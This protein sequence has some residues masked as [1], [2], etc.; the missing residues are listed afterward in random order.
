MPKAKRSLNSI[1]FFIGADSFVLKQDVTAM[2][3]QL[4]ADDPSASL[5]TLDGA[6]A[7]MEEILMMA[8]TPALFAQK[9]ILWIKNYK[10]LEKAAGKDDVKL[11]KDLAEGIPEDTQIVFTGVKADNRLKFVSE[12]KKMAEFIEHETTE[13]WFRNQKDAI[14]GRFQQRMEEDAFDLLYEFWKDN[15]AGFASELEKIS[16]YH[17]EQKQAIGL[18]EIL[19]VACLQK[20]DPFYKFAE[21]L[22]NKNR[23]GALKVLQSIL[24]QEDSMIG[25]I[26]YLLNCLRFLMQARALLDQGLIKASKISSQYRSTS[27]QD[28]IQSLP[29]DLLDETPR[30]C[31][32]LKQHPYRTFIFLRQAMNFTA[33][34]LSNLFLKT[35]QAYWD[36]VNSRP[37]DKTLEKLVLSI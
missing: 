9:R 4:Q 19:N 1:Y 11:L 37:A 3:D 21:E 6:Q 29:A 27:M 26:S 2:L 5:E 13:E 17:G 10:G 32:L 34:Q 12:L 16:T 25:V 31:H 14:L 28:V 20:E 15:P 7:S 22:L 24:M 8:Q 33:A 18:K 23:A 36:S 30:E 35:C